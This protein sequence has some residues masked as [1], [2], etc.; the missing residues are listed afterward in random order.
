MARRTGLL[1]TQPELIPNGAIRSL[2]ACRT[3][4]PPN[5]MLYDVEFSI[6]DSP[7]LCRAAE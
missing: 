1:A 5:M 3:F 7:A 2:L 6:G 4:L